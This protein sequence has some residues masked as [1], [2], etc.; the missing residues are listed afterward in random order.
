MG[1]IIAWTQQ[2]MPLDTTIN[3]D[4]DKEEREN[5]EREGEM[6]PVKKV[7]VFSQQFIGTQGAG[8]EAV[9]TGGKTV[10]ARTALRMFQSKLPGWLGGGMKNT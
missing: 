1:G 9:V 2:G 6:Q 10:L 5:N 4:E 7:H 3:N 8:Y